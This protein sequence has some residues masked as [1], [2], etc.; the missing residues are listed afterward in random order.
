ML[1][2]RDSLL[3]H[4][5]VASLVTSEGWTEFCAEANLGEYR[6]GNYGRLE[7]GDSVLS[8]FIQSAAYWCCCDRNMGEM[9][10]TCRMN[11]EMLEHTYLLNHSMQQSPSWETNRFSA[12]QEIPHILWNPKVHY[13]IHKCP[14]HVSILTQSH[15]LKIH[16]NI[17]LPS[18]P[19]SPKWFLSLRFPHLNPQYASPVLHTRYMPHPSHSSRFHHAHNIG[20][21]VQIIKLLIT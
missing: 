2:E 4:T 16:L 17:I 5:C 8:A 15:F 11:Q 1:S 3:R 20:W 21:G 13:R 10:G 9:D 6:N 19:G 7:G 12:S 14:P 18:T